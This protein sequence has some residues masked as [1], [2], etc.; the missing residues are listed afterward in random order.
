[1]ERRENGT[2]TK[3]ESVNDLRL[4]TDAARIAFERD[5]STLEGMVEDVLM[6][7]MD[8]AFSDMF[9]QVKAAYSPVGADDGKLTVVHYTKVKVVI[10]M[11][12]SEIREEPSYLRMYDTFHSNDP[13][14]GKYLITR[15]GSSDLEKLKEN[16]DDTPPCAYVASFIKPETECSLDVART[17]DNLVFWRTYGENGA[18]ISLTVKMP[19]DKLFEIAYGR[20]KA[21]AG[22]RNLIRISEFINEALSPVLGISDEEGSIQSVKGRLWGKLRE[23]AS[24]IHYLHKSEA[25]N[26]EREFRAIATITDSESDQIKFERI[27][28]SDDVRH[29]YEREDL[30][31]RNLLATGSVITIGPCVPNEENIA[32]YL[33]YLKRKSG[34]AGPEI[35]QSKVSYRNN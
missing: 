33:E 16:M 6:P 2:L 1:M 21:E 24:P 22:A 12:R 11:F 34:L 23:L 3:P 30:R 35:V 20:E 26:Y 5:P 29:Y 13:E 18:G 27:D 9:T 17:R 32:Y 4:M 14:E 8:K 10:D 15:L 25:Y 31:A 7:Q 28:D 19:V